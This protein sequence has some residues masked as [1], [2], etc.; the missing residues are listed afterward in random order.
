MAKFKSAIPTIFLHE[1][2]YVNHPNDPGGETNFGITKRTYPHLD[3]KN[4]TK[5]QA[6]KIYRRDFLN[7]GKY[8]KI[9]NQQAATKVF[10]LAVNMGPRRAHRLLQKA[11]RATNKVPASKL[12]QELRAVAVLFYVNLVFKNADRA[13]FLRGWLRRAVS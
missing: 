2:G 8:E 12:L 10:D 11:V 4:L 6:R 5:A 3:I 7:P 13:V 9:D 1:G